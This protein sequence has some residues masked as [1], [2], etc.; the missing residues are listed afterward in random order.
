MTLIISL[1]D[2]CL[3]GKPATVFLITFLS[4]RGNLDVL[5]YSPYRKIK[6][7]ALETDSALP[8]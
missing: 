8:R 3:I 6:F 2:M 4:L 5:V 7:H 1:S